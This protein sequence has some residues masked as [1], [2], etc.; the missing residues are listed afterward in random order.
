MEQQKQKQSEKEERIRKARAIVKETGKDAGILEQIEF[1]SVGEDEE[2]VYLTYIA[3]YLSSSQLVSFAE[4]EW[5]FNIYAESH[6]DFEI[7][8]V[9][10]KALL[11]EEDIKEFQKKRWTGE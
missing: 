5:V 7:Q 1:Q 10:P 6:I 3:D 11:E 9:I 4:P 2:T 8:V